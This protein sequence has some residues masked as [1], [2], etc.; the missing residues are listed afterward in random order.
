MDRPVTPGGQ[1]AP[2]VGAGSLTDPDGGQTAMGFLNP[3]VVSAENT[4][5][6]SFLCHFSR[7]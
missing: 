6:L 1:T 4:C 2:V 3:L 5:P 7:N